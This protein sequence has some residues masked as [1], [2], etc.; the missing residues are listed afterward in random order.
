MR[1]LAAEAMRAGAF[2]FSTSRT[3][4]HKTLAGDPTPTLRAQE[5][6]L[7]GIALGLTDAGSGMIELVS[8]WNTPDAATEFA[9]VRRIVEATGRPLV[10][11]LSQRHDRTNDWRTLLALSDQAARDGLAI[12]PVF[13]P[14]PIGILFGLLGSQNPFSGTPAYKAIAHLPLPE[15]VAAMRDPECRARILSEDPLAGSNFPLLARLSYARMFPFGDPPDYEPPETNAIAA[16][17]ARQG[18]SAADVA[19]D[20]LLADEGKSFLFAPLTNYA[21]YSLAPCAE[22]LAHPNTIVGLSDG[23]AHVG[24]IS[25]ASFPTYLLTYWGRDRSTGR[26]P[27]EDLIR[28]QTSDTARAVGLSDR[29]ILRPGLR[30]D[31]NIID[32]PNLTLH[33]PDMQFDL[34]AGG[35]RL[36]Q[37]ATGYTATIVA[38]QITYRNGTA[39]GALPGRLVRAG[40]T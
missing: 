16:I 2:G 25:D 39:T 3:I 7:T 31:I 36:L 40:R 19:Y 17:A 13:P 18:R 24:F 1:R 10:F 38:G 12:R 22:M 32:F 23:G 29:G 21:D 15:R 11:S 20:L 14:R 35:R 33:R 8:D 9:M 26:Q 6:E 28:R 4:S 37:K 5:D 34:P 30:A 27:V